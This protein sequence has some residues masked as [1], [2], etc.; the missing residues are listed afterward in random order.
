MAYVEPTTDVDVY[1]A[2]AEKLGVTRPEA[3]ELVIRQL[4]SN[5]VGGG[6]HDKVGHFHKKFGLPGMERPPHELTDEEALFRILFMVEELGEYADASGFMNLAAVLYT[7]GHGLKT[8][9]HSTTQRTSTRN[10]EK[11]LDG[12]VD[13]VYVALGTSLFHGFD[14][15]TAFDEVH[16]ANMRKV[17]V[18]RLED[19]TRGSRFDVVKPEG[20]TP[21]DLRRF[22]K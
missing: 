11:Q 13:L 10:F 14:F 9:D 17:R 7:V 20:W 16:E 5:V 18:E 1:S 2:L 3:K 6:L 21:P 12:L 8:R 19:S 4:Y 15:D 22:L